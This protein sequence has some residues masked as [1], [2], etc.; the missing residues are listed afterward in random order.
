[1]PAKAGPCEPAPEERRKHRDPLLSWCRSWSDWLLSRA[2]GWGTP[3][4]GR[5]RTLPGQAR[6]RRREQRPV[7]VRAGT[8]RYSGLDPCASRPLRPH[9]AA[10]QAGV[11]RRNHRHCR[12]ARA[13]TID[14]ARCGALAGGGR[15]ARR[16]QG[17]PARNC[18]GRAAVL[19]CRCH[20]VI[21]SLR[22]DAGL[23]RAR[24]TERR[25][26]DHLDRRRTPSCGRQCGTRCAGAAT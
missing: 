26:S 23:R 18:A 6:A 19:C 5:L 7:R 14:P 11:S 13:R 8:D 21:R 22:P 12:H 9:S 15:E 1:M 4:A 17:A 24:S 16:A 20:V 2:R 10:G 3:S 25:S